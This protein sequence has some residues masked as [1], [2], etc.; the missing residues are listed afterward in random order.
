VPRKTARLA[1]EE[2]L[3]LYEQDK[4]KR[5]LS[6]LVKQARTD[7]GMSQVALEYQLDPFSRIVDM[8]K[9]ISSIKQQLTD[10]ETLVRRLP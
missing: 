7:A 9:D 2:L 4:R 5:D 10:I 6:R 8:A 3:A 1:A